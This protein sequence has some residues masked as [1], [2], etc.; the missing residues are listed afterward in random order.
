MEI[1]RC[2]GR[3]ADLDV[4]FSGELKKTF[5]ACAGMFRSLAFKAV[6]EKQDD[7]GG[8]IP[9]ILTCANELVDDDLRA[10]NE[11]PELRFPQNKSFGI[12]AAETV[13]KTEAAGFRK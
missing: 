13:F 6:G 3:L 8:K 12:V 5:E 2:V 7:A 4:V 10:V 9:L 11:I 1:L